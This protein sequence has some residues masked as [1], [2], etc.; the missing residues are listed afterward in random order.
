MSKNGSRMD[1]VRL[2][3]FLTCLMAC[4]TVSADDV[5]TL[6]RDISSPDPIVRMDACKRAGAIGAQAIAPVAALLV[7][8]DYETAKTARMAME[9]IVVYAA[10]PGAESERRNV[11]RELARLLG[12]PHPISTKTEA[13]R[14]IAWIGEDEEAAAITPLLEEEALADEVRMSL[15]RIPG[16]ASTRALLA[17]LDHAPTHLRIGLLNS[18]GRKKNPGTVDQLKEFAQ[19]SERDVAWACLETLAALAVPPTQVFPAPTCAEFARENPA[20]Y[21]QITLDAATALAASGDTT[22]AE[23]LYLQVPSLTPLPHLRGAALHGLTRIQSRE[24]LILGLRWLGDPDLRLYAARA[25]IEADR[26]DTEDHLTA[27]FVRTQGYRRAEL[28]RILSARGYPDLP[29]LI[30]TALSDRSAEV[31]IAA[32]EL[33]GKVPSLDDFREALAL[34]SPWGKE[35]A[36]WFAVETAQQMLTNQDG[37][38]AAELCGLVTRAKTDTKTTT[39]AFKILE[40]AAHPG[41]LALMKE[42]FGASFEPTGDGLLTDLALALGPAFAENKT[43]RIAAERAYVAVCGALEDKDAANEVLRAVAAKS[44][45]PEVVGLAGALLDARGMDTRLLAAQQGYITDWRILGPFPNE[46][47]RAATVSFF[48]E[49]DP[50][51]P[52]SVDYE[53]TAYQWQPVRAKGI[54]AIVDLRKHL[55]PNRNRAAYAHAEIHVQKDQTVLFHIGSDDGCLFWVNGEKRLERPGS[56][57]FTANEDSV[58]AQLKTGPNFIL[59]K[60]LQS[61]GDW[62][63]CVRVTDETGAPIDWTR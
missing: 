52:E 25:L 41:S 26:A 36:A 47:N 45:F 49:E 4:L 62:L 10:R 42:I 5:E 48:R 63:F 23:S 34:S 9:R 17:A 7:H 33:A 55:T 13:L 35:H 30:E 20:R 53:G 1:V 19:Q 16:E 54:P 18:L 46:E 50:A 32:A 31:R 29:A 58:S 60:V 59:I 44:Q 15:E 3:G 61:A 12:E 14:L 22:A 57:R 24:G 51:P 6:L 37:A 38:G 11:A 43:L 2:A 56:R 40:Q 21:A 39:E 27:A 28:L 8:S